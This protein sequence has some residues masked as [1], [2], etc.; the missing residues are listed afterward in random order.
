[1]A[2]H[3]YGMTVLAGLLLLGACESEDPNDPEYWIKQLKSTR[4]S[5][6]I[7]QLGRMAEGGGDKGSLARKAVPK[8]VQLYDADKDR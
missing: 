2:F 3:R 1:M 4:R 5:E 8:L 6:A 7:K